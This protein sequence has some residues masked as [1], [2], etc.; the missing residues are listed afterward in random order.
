MGCKNIQIIRHSTVH[1]SILHLSDKNR[2]PK[3]NKRPRGLDTL[4]GHLLVKRIPVMY[5]LSTTKIPEYLTQK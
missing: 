5:K 4:L 1:P 3:L 2:L